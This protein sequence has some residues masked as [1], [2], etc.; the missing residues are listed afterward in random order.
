ML[1]Y[2][3]KKK[4]YYYFLCFHNMNSKTEFYLDMMLNG[5]HN[6]KLINQL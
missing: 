2:N 4:I 1:I 5:S 6:I 3:N